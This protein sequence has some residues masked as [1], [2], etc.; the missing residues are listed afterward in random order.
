M[1][2]QTFTTGQVLTAA[3]MTSLQETAMGGGP[4][5]AK[6]ASYVLVA[7]DAGKTVAMNAAGATTITVNTGLFEAG[8][9]VFIQNLGTGACTV[10]AG[11]ATVATAGSLILPQNDAGILYFTSASTA[12]FYDYIQT[13]A[14]SPL[15]TK[16]DLYGY[17]TSDARIPIGANGTVLT[18]DSTEALGLKWATATS[19]AVNFTLINTGG[20]SLSGSTT[21]VSGI[22]GKN[23]LAIFIEGLSLTGTQDIGQRLRLNSDTGSNYF[24][25]VVGRNNSNPASES[26]TGTSIFLGVPNSSSNTADCLILIEGCNATGNKFITYTFSGNATGTNAKYFN[27]HGRYTG[28]SAISS[29]SILTDSETYDAGTVYVYGA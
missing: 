6:T 24:Y 3:Q 8:D 12:I 23:S 22:S 26:G 28:T 15:T 19:P 2:K 16:G 1:A 7:A 18:A 25:A 29:I 27:G 10:T 17:S 5:T 21:T 4:A 13:G 14:A 9:T 20:T 11:T